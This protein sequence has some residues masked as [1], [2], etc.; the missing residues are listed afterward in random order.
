MSTFGRKH[1][2][3]KFKRFFF[4]RV[5][6]TKP[7]AS[8]H[9]PDSVRCHVLCGNRS[10][11]K[12]PWRMASQARSWRDDL[13]SVWPQHATRNRAD[14][15]VWKQTA[16][17]NGCHTRCRTPPVHPHGTQ[18]VST[19]NRQRTVL[20]GHTCSPVWSRALPPTWVGLYYSAT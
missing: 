12:S 8:E 18:C 19:A 13:Y 9:N 10:W 3:L 7:V 1:T 2:G 16:S 14:G 17:L 5:V 4:L 11:S 20:A 15:T 6:F